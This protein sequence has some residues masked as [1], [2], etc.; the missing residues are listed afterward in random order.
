MNDDIN[1]YDKIKKMRQKYIFI[2]IATLSFWIRSMAS[3]ASK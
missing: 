3:C 2:P 1:V